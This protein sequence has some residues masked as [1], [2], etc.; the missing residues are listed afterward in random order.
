MKIGRSGRALSSRSEPL[1]R[2]ASTDL[3]AMSQIFSVFLI[4]FLDDPK[5]LVRSISCWAIR[6]FS[7]W[8]CTPENETALQN[9]VHKILERFLDSN[10]RVREAAC[11]A[12]AGIEEEA[13]LMLMPYWDQILQ[14]FAEALQYYQTRGF[15]LLCDACAALGTASGSSLSE[16]AG[17]LPLVTRLL[18]ELPPPLQESVKTVPILEAVTAL[19]PAISK[20]NPELAAEVFV[21]CVSM[22]AAAAESQRSQAETRSI[23]QE[24]RDA[25]EQSLCCLSAF[26][27]T[28]GEM[29]TAIPVLP[30][31]A[32]LLEFLCLEPVFAQ[33]A[34]VRQMTFAL[35][36]DLSRHCTRHLLPHLQK[37]VPAMA[38]R[39]CGGSA[40]VAN[41]AAWALGEL[42]VH[43]G[44]R[45]MTPFAPVAAEQLAL[46]IQRHQLHQVPL[47][48]NA[49]ISMGRLSGV[50]P[51]CVAPLLGAF[52]KPWSSL[53]VGAKNDEDKATAIRGICRSFQYNPGEVQNALHF[54]LDAFGSNF[55][56]PQ[57]GASD[58][59]VP[60]PPFTVAL[61]EFL[62]EILKWMR[63]TFPPSA[64]EVLQM[65][66]PA[67]RAALVEQG[68]IS[69]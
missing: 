65:L 31:L 35:I 7:P 20:A 36:G 16:A 11:S 24:L 32:K 27:E 61:R 51:Q 50:T 60:P 66:R 1:L 45:E 64:W 25:I 44:E 48:R 19:S 17:L 67:T 47:L 15:I 55:I 28:L 29:V 63:A 30:M 10:K 43:L 13:G 41:N 26:T 8:A 14:R 39:I 40:N 42:A 69:S 2:G 54:V 34:S 5:P 3:P 4:S 9:I 62:M 18:R 21:R 33:F 53:M 52:L 22:I 57:E 46:L 23:P 6:R 38:S 37:I 56:Q 49:C 59:R 68:L 58:G 12:F